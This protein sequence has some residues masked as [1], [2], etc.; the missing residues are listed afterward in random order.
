MIIV[1]SML[2]TGG[3]GYLIE[4]FGTLFFLHVLGVLSVPYAW[5]QLG[6]VH[7]FI[8]LTL[9]GA[10]AVY[11]GHLLARLYRIVP[12]ARVLADVGQLL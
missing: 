12:K 3:W 9:L 11:S 7:G 1:A 6:W 8:L 4:T 5:A 2:G 10:G